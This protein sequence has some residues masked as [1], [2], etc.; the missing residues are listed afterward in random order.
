MKRLLVALL[1]GGMVF[2]TVL[3]IAAGLNVSGGTIQGGTDDDLICDE[4]G[5]YVDAWGLNTYPVLEGVEYVTIKGVDAD[6]DGA[7]IMGRVELTTSVPNDNSTWVYT[8]GVD[9][10][11]NGQYFVIAN[12]N[13]TTE[14]RLFLKEADYATQTYVLAE[15]IVAI[16]LWIEG[17]AND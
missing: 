14:Y 17:N 6:C 1:V 15:D 3:A 16:K 11:G 5:I 10:N 13:S 12:G 8:S 2:G 4:G 7:R 9:A